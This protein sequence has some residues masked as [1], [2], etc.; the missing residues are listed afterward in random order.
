[1]QQIVEQGIEELVTGAAVPIHRKAVGMTAGVDLRFSLQRTLR[2]LYDRQIPLTVVQKYEPN[3]AKPA[4]MAV[5]VSNE[6]TVSGLLVCN[7]AAAAY[8]GAALSLLP[9]A[10]A[11]DCIRKN[12]L[13]DSLLENF[14]EF[15]NILSSLFAE[16]LGERIHLDHVIA[17]VTASPEKTASLNAPVRRWDFSLE[18]PNY[19][20]GTVSIRITKH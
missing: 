7:I 10:A 2:D 8:F 6:Q 19:G 1:V 12:Q 11:E 9:K 3:A 4:T 13:D 17:K 14:H 5:Y 15:A 16:Q 20:A 18:I